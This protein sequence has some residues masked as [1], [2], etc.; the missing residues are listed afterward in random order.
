MIHGKRTRHLNPVH[1][2]AATIALLVSLGLLGCSSGEKSDGP[3]AD[4]IDVSAA[5]D[6][7][8][9]IE[10]PSRYGNPPSYRVNGK[11]YYTL[12]SS[13]NYRKR[14]VASWYGGKFHG[15]LTSS[16][17]PYD[18]Y[19]MTAAHRTLP[20]PTYARVTNLRN[21]RSVVLRI[22]DRG[23]FHAN[24]VIDLSY[25]AATRLGIVHAGTGL[26]EVT[27]IDP[28]T[29]KT[30][31]PRS[32]KESTHPPPR[33]T[34]R[35]YLQ[36]GAFTNRLNAEQ[37]QA[38]IPPTVSEAVY[39][40]KLERNPQPLYQVRIG[41]LESAQLADNLSGE[42]QQQLGLAEMHVVVE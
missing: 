20:L 1:V 32:K 34:P 28:T 4:G 33:P 30:R 9:R 42:L 6:A 41:P 8:P 18:M 23:P 29:P 3:P 39:I 7:V 14:G 35:L 16:R 25:A 27:A 31:L 5:P 2:R 22:N 13:R 17:E 26:V 10:P 36:I 38:R 19:A 40:Q 15:R 12:K 11:R 24:R 37:L 21:D